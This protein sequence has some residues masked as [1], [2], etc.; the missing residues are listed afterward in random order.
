[1][2]AGRA[3]A[4]SLPVGTRSRVVFRSYARRTPVFTL[5]TGGVLVSLTL[6]ER[7]SAAHV[8]FARG[9]AEHA[10]AY[11]TAVERIYRNS[12]GGKAAA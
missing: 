7:L 12:T 10:A 2:A 4:L 11:A 3:S 6:P 9:L 8:E 1:M 5:T